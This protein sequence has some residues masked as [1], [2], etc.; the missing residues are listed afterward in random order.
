MFIPLMSVAL[1]FFFVQDVHF[2]PASQGQADACRDYA[3][4][5][6]LLLDERVGASPLNTGPGGRYNHWRRV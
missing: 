5:L 1:F 2:P 6:F 3:H 4:G